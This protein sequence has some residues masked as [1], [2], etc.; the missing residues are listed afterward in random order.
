MT[1]PSV[2]ADGAGSPKTSG[3]AVGDSKGSLAA[4]GIGNDVSPARCTDGEGSTSSVESA[5][6]CTVPGSA[7]PIAPVV[8]SVGRFPL[9]IRIGDVAAVGPAAAAGPCVALPE[10]DISRC[11][12]GIDPGELSGAPSPSGRDGCSGPAWPEAA[13]SADD[14]CTPNGPCVPAGVAGSRTRINAD[15]PSTGASAAASLS[16]VSGGSPAEVSA[17]VR[18]TGLGVVAA[19]ESTERCTGASAGGAGPLRRSRA[20]C[21]SGALCSEDVSLAGTPRVVGVE[22]ADGADGGDDP[23]VGAVGAVGIVG[24]AGA[25]GEK[26]DGP[27]EVRGAPKPGDRVGAGP[28]ADRWTGAVRPSGAGLDSWS[29]GWLCAATAEFSAAALLSPSSGDDI[30]S[31]GRLGSGIVVTSSGATSC[32]P[33][34]D[35]ADSQRPRPIHQRLRVPGARHRNGRCRNGRARLPAL[36]H[37]AR[38]SAWTARGCRAALTTGK[39]VTTGRGVAVSCTGAEVKALGAA[40]EEVVLLSW[41]TGGSTVAAAGCSGGNDAAAGTGLGS[42]SRL[43][44]GEPHDRRQQALHRGVD[45]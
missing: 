3:L 32:P 30:V 17:W 16:A 4:L 1:R 37:V 27:D 31:A 38:R 13:A 24:T 18:T 35:P 12:P 45:R 20:G 8:R 5:K 19:L 6:R 33:L 43:V 25:L 21:D 11:T 36:R 9:C 23:I 41:R 42:R 39:S 34:D 29:G 10:V 26:D 44:V 2:G 22:V 15:I 14:R 28:A 7:L 40:E